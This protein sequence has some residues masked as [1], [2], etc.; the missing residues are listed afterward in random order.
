MC[1]FRRRIQIRVI[2]AAQTR[3]ANSLR[4]AQHSGLVYAPRALAANNAAS[5]INS[6]RRKTFWLNTPPV[7]ANFSMTGG[8]KGCSP[9]MT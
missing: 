2:H 5:C 1:S 6:R 3:D 9:C 7:F 4:R 8:G